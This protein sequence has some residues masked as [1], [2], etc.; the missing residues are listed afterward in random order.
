MRNVEKWKGERHSHLGHWFDTIIQAVIQCIRDRK[1]ERKRE[2][3]W[4]SK[5]R[6]KRT[7]MRERKWEG[8]TDLSNTSQ[9]G[10]G[11]FLRLSVWGKSLNMFFRT[12][13]FPLNSSNFLR[14]WILDIEIRA[15]W[16]NTVFPVK[17]SWVRKTV[18][19][20]Q[21]PGSNYLSSK[22]QIF[23]IRGEVP[24][25]YC[26]RHMVMVMHDLVGYLGKCAYLVSFLRPVW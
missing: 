4:Q 22:L 7:L 10:I 2:M 19:S 26:L 13:Q 25:R 15:E 5:R 3:G 1:N 18:G 21:K 9:L 17:I 16:V 8:E 11:C 23:T 14:K 20:E 24:L 12:S 6:L